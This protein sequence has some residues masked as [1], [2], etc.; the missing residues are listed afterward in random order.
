MTF[1]LN[2][3]RLSVFLLRLGTNQGYPL[4]PFLF[5][6]L[7]VLAGTIGKKQK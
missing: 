5:I 1:I 4:E 3:K 7:E 2:D 6:I